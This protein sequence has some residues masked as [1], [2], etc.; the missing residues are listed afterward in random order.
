[1]LTAIATVFVNEDSSATGEAARVPR[2]ASDMTEP[3]PAPT[4]RAVDDAQHHEG[5][6]Q[7]E[8]FER[9]AEYAVRRIKRGERNA[10]ARRRQC[11]GQIDN[12]VEYSPAGETIARQSPG[13]Q[14]AENDVDGRRRQRDAERHA[15]RRQH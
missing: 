2:A 8:L 1:M 11:E 9:R 10:G 12:G 5:N 7:S 4:L 13:D 3:P 15:Q 6:A 14:Q